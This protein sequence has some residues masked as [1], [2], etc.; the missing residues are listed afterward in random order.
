MLVNGYLMVSG[1][2][3]KMVIL[4]LIVILSGLW[5]CKVFWYLNEGM[6]FGVIGF[7]I[8]IDKMNFCNYDNLDDNEEGKL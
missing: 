7:G 4:L 1:F 8:D 5:F 6:I 3:C 2:F